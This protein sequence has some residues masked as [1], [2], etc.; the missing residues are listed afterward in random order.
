LKATITKMDLPRLDITRTENYR[1][2]NNQKLIEILKDYV[3]FC[4][5]QRLRVGTNLS[6]LKYY[7]QLE[8][9]FYKTKESYLGK[10]EIR[11]RI[12]FIGKALFW[13]KTHTNLQKCIYENSAYLA[14][15][16]DDECKKLYVTSRKLK[17]LLKEKTCQQK[18]KV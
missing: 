9:C 12:E 6:V 11:K 10:H 3:N 7:N 1:I 18:E 14:K 4:E 2:K 8:H 5:K 17:P 15:K 13:K 16:Y